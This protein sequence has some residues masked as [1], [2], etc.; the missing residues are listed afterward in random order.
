MMPKEL[1]IKL[2][3]VFNHF[4]NLIRKGLNEMEEDIF[5]RRFLIVTWVVVSSL[6]ALIIL[7]ATMYFKVTNP[8]APIPEVLSNW[9]G[10]ILG[11]YFGSFT[12]FAKDVILRIR[13]Y[14]NRTNIENAEPQNH[15]KLVGK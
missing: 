4:T 3:K 9:G 2:S 11:F 10:I 13:N 1:L 5:L 15:E 8:T 12:T 7:G 14:S 6:I